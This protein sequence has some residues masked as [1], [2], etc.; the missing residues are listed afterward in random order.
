MCLPEYESCHKAEA[1]VWKKQHSFM[2]DRGN[3]SKSMAKGKGILLNKNLNLLLSRLTLIDRGIAFQ[4]LQ[5]IRETRSQILAGW[6]PTFQPSCGGLCTLSVCWHLWVTLW[7]VPTNKP[8]PAIYMIVYKHTE[9][10]LLLC[11]HGNRPGHWCMSNVI[12]TH[13]STTP[14]RA[15]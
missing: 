3:V 13:F 8:H 2:L 15:T 14:F 4:K 10:V 9:V 11:G 7:N 5:N 1:K 12:I 6:S